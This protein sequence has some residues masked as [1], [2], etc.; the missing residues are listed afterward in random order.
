MCYD[1]EEYS[2]ENGHH[3]LLIVLS[4]ATNHHTFF[5]LT[6]QPH[7]FVLVYTRVAERLPPLVFVGVRL[8]A[9]E[10]AQILHQ[11]STAPR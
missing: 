1:Q 5:F 7:F 4:C 10:N 8:K 2:V 9:D 3:K 6:P 11:H